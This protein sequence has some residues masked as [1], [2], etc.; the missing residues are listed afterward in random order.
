MWDRRK[1]LDAYKAIVVGNSSMIQC[2]A[3]YEHHMDFAARSAALIL[4]HNVKLDRVPRQQSILTSRATFFVK[5]QNVHA[6]MFI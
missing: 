2:T 1:V 6:Y 5:Y 4:Q 3:F